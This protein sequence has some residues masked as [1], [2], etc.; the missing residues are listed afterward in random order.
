MYI[1]CVSVNHV[2]LY[3]PIL[4]IILILLLF[5]I[6]L[7]FVFELNFFLEELRFGGIFELFII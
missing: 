2:V 4:I 7:L 5:Y 6:L 1:C 3:Y